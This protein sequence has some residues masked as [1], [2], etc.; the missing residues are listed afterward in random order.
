MHSETLALEVMNEGEVEQKVFCDP[1]T[2][3]LVAKVILS[4]ISVYKACKKTPQ[5]ATV[6]CKTMSAVERRVVKRETRKVMGPIKYFLNGHKIS[7]KIIGRAQKLEES[8]LVK[9]YGEEV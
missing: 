4:L 7:E 8:D 5:Q 1:A 6:S 9:L 3:I 2:V